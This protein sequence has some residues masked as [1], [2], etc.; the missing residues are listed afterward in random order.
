MKSLSTHITESFVNEA[1]QDVKS[2]AK[3]GFDLVITKDLREGTDFKEISE[4]DFDRYDEVVVSPNPFGVVPTIIEKGTVVKNVKPQGNYIMGELFAVSSR[5]GRNKFVGNIT[6]TL[7]SISI[8]KI[9]EPVRGIS[10][11]DISK[12]LYDAVVYTSFIVTDG[13]NTIGFALGRGYDD[14]MADKIIAAL[15]Q[16]GNKLNIQIGAS[17]GGDKGSECVYYS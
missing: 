10:A 15:S 12:A 7:D 13:D 8:L 3:S 5:N 11:L 17:A 4:E 16:F 14:E 6:L 1:V 9:P 2:A